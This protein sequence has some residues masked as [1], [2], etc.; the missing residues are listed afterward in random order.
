MRHALL[1]ADRRLSCLPQAGVHCV[2]WIRWTHPIDRR[3]DRHQDVEP[4][5]SPRNSVVS[6]LAPARAVVANIDD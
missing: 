2:Q 4:K 5:E 6:L 1:A 3:R